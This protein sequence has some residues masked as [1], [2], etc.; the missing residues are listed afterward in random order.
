MLHAVSQ[1]RCYRDAMTLDQSFNII[2]K[3]AGTDFDPHP[4]R[5]F[6]EAIIYKQQR[7][8]YLTCDFSASIL[9]SSGSTMHSIVMKQMLPPMTLETGSARNTPEVP[10][11]RT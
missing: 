7:A 2:E 4:A 6:L 9:L 1:K 11:P 10:M 3:G 8:Y 5:L